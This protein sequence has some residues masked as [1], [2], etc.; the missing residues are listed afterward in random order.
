MGTLFASDT[1]PHGGTYS[2]IRATENLVLNQGT[3]LF[4]RL[5]QMPQEPHLWLALRL[6]CDKGHTSVACRWRRSGTWARPAVGRVVL[7]LR[8]AG[9]CGGSPASRH[10]QRAWCSGSVATAN[11]ACARP[12]QP[13]SSI[14]IHVKEGSQT[15]V[16]PTRSQTCRVAAAGR[17]RGFAHVTEPRPPARCSRKP[18][19]LRTSICASAKA[20]RRRRPA[21]GPGQ[22]VAPVNPTTISKLPNLDAML[23]QGIA[24]LAR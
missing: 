20:T 14:S 6:A 15:L 1:W 8:L 2:Q 4:C 18:C 16:P 21:R 7:R 12:S 3:G 17:R 22:R 10:Q 23:L 5:S 9:G 19:G 13:P 24:H 11:R